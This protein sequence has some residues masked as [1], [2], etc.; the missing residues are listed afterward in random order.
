VL[1]FCIEE[2]PKA[3]HRSILAQRLHEDLGGT[4]EHLVTS[5]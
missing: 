1:V 5:R 2:V 3:C 4:I